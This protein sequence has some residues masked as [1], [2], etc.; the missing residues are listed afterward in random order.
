M[1]NIE[2]IKKINF[3]CPC[4]GK[5]EWKKE[6]VI[7]EEI[8]CGTLDVEICNK[9]GNQ[10]LPDWSMEIVENKLKEAGLWGIK[11]KE[12][13]FWKS[14]NSIII[15][16]PVELVRKLGIQNIKKGYAY[17]EGKNK[18]SIEF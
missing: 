6:K 4:G 3:P 17:E 2:K 13:K 11:R 9:C 15:R 7:Q 8:D 5:I 1:K 16:F 18:L 12:I 10:Y 14:G